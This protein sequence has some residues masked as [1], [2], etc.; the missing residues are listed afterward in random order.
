MA[1]RAVLLEECKNVEALLD[2]TLRH[3]YGLDGSQDFYN[4]CFT[5]LKFNNS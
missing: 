1:A 2:G 5:R 3:E 4:E